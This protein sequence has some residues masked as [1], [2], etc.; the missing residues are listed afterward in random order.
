[1]VRAWGIPW[2]SSSFLLPG[3][4][5]AVLKQLVAR[6]LGTVTQANSSLSCSVFQVS[7]P[8]VSMSM[9]VHMGVYI[10]VCTYVCTRVCA[11]V[12][13]REWCQASSSNTLYR[14]CCVSI[15]LT[16]ELTDPAR[17][18]DQQAWH[19]PVSTF[20]ELGLQACT[21]Y[22]TFYMGAGDLSLGPCLRCQALY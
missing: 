20:P 15:L 4:Q 21:A 10:C 8:W 22:A 12:E 2:V 5:E 7:C 3:R 1:M 17:L 11:Y 18:P 19:L 6:H 9:G 13:A 16:L 14:I